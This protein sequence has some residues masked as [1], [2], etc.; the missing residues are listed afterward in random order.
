MPRPH[1]L[2]KSKQDELQQQPLDRISALPNTPPTVLLE[3]P[4]PQTDIS[5]GETELWCSNPELGSNKSDINISLEPLSNPELGGNKRDINSLEPLLQ[6]LSELVEDQTN[7][8]KRMS[9]IMLEHR[10]Q[11]HG[12]AGSPCNGHSSVLDVDG[13]KVTWSENHGPG[14]SKAGA[15][16]NG[17]VIANV[18]EL[19]EK[20]HQK[21]TTMELDNDRNKKKN[22]VKLYGGRAL[23][24]QCTVAPRPR[25]QVPSFGDDPVEFCRGMCRKL[26]SSR[27]FDPIIGLIIFANAIC[28]G[29]SI[30]WE[31]RGR[32]TSVLSA[33]ESIFLTL[34]ILELLLQVIAK[35]IRCLLHGWHLFD[36][37]VI[38][39]GV[40]TQ[41]VFVT[42]MP[43]WQITDSLKQILVLRMLRLLKLVRALRLLSNFRALWKLTHSFMQCAPTMASAL[44]IMVMTIYIFA[45]V[46]V[47]FI[48]KGEWAGEEVRELVQRNFS[49]LPVTMLSLVQFVTGDGISGLYYPLILQKPFLCI[50][51]MALLMAV[52]LA[53]MN[54]V[55]AM[56]VEDAI[57]S[58]RMDEE[59]EAMYK[60]KQIKQLVP[61]LT[62]LYHTLDTSSDQYVE[63]D[64][65]INAIREGIRIPMDLNGIVT[66]DRV[67][68]LFD[69]FD[70]D[71]DGRL[72]EDEFVT[73][74]CHVALA[75]VPIEMTQVL[76][77]VRSCN[78]QLWRMERRLCTEGVHIHHD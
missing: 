31:V 30:D 39:G 70:M 22:G 49:S 2:W 54:L 33:F 78:L 41:W 40:I 73:G 38:S 74:M 34:F 20:K 23:E 47:E 14:Q 51:F 75:N 13:C 35:G 32:D 52:T 59:M 44:L 4:H 60:R 11:Y 72:S 6:Q 62:D 18:D 64:E 77:M 16:N 3:A 17:C 71:C 37:F 57:S 36:L 53:L 27:A 19:P 28:L 8:A 76:H 55:T 45:C 50:Y 42:T 68:D 66:E 29:I 24:N 69:A 10:K 48:A 5:H 43:E 61:A 1:S 63:M 9:I 15:H 65:I 25:V 67:V 7:I 56:V 26:V 46:G 12:T 21:M 58:A